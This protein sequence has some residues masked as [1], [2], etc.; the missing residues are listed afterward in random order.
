V[1]E[2]ITELADLVRG[3]ARGRDRILIGITGGPGSGKSTL[4]DRLCAEL[5]AEAVVIG[6]DGFHYA[7]EELTRRE[8]TAIKGAPETFDGAGY[9]ALLRRLRTPVDGETVYAPRFSREL[10]E[11]IGSAVPVP[12]ETR[13]VI[14]EGNYLLVD[15]PPWDQ[16]KPLLDAVWFVDPG[17]YVRVTRLVRRHVRFGRT[18]YEALRRATTGSDATN[19]A[20]IDATRQR[21]DLVIRS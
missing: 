3:L 18:E 14:T 13:F 6:M 4:A 1:T 11:P 7:Q 2:S 5:G 8:L 10:E 16:V 19:A 9:V 17:E 20:L 12:P 21:A 15:A